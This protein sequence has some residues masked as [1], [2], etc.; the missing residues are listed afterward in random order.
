M[1]PVQ[2]FSVVDG[3]VLNCRITLKGK[4][5]RFL[6][7]MAMCAAMTGIVGAESG[8][9]DTARIKAF[10]VDFNWG[11]AGFAPPGMYAGLRRRSIWRGTR[12]WG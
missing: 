5:M 9:A 10:C 3:A 12:S 2:P 11:D 4:A 8:T 7:R 6:M 1:A